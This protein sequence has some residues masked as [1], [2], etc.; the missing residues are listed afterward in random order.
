V[1][2]GAGASEN[3]NG[4][5]VYHK[6]AFT[7]ATADLILPTGRDFASREVYDGVSLRVIR[8]YDINNDQFPCRVDVLFGKLAQRAGLAARIHADG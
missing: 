3:L 8:D 5:L 7:V 6:S 2:V 4:S 1:K